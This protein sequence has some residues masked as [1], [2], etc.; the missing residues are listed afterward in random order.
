MTLEFQVMNTGAGPA[1]F[2]ISKGSYLGPGGPQ[3]DLGNAIFWFEI[4]DGYL[5]Y[6]EG[7]H[8]GYGGIIGECTNDEWHK[9]MVKV[10][11]FTSADVYIDDVFAGTAS[12][13]TQSPVTE[14]TH[15]HLGASGT[16]VGGNVADA[17]FDAVMSG[18]IF[19]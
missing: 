13:H 14:I 9:I 8:P 16:D 12:N 4:E 1:D 15:I 11:S 2:A 3:T 17:Y 19:A 10:N 5:R 18:L 7:G 6:S